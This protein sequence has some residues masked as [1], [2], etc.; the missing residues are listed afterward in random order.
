MTSAYATPTGRER[1][2]LA[3]VKL[4]PG[5]RHLLSVGGVGTGLGLTIRLETGPLERFAL[6]GH[7]VSYR[8]CVG[9]CN[10]MGQGTMGRL[11]IQTVR[12]RKT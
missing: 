5:N 9:T 11:F 3:L 1:K 4:R 2:G 12:D 8:R 10:K 6:V 7:C